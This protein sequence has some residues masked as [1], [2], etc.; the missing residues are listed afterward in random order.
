MGDLRC[1]VGGSRGDVVETAGAG[2]PDCCG[3]GDCRGGV[4]DSRGGVVE[5]VGAGGGACSGVD[6][7]GIP[8]RLRGE[9]SLAG[10][11]SLSSAR[12]LG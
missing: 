4:G 10:H 2:S 8:T 3:V 9:L 11:F 1:G 5:T 7:T 12:N 6:M